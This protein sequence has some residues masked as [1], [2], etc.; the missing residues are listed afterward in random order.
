MNSSVIKYIV[1]N[2]NEIKIVKDHKIR[3][4]IEGEMQLIKKVLS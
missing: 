1:L 3:L 4:K 2:Q